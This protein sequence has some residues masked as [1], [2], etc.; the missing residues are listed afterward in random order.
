MA[1][2]KMLSVVLCLVALCWAAPTKIGSGRVDLPY[3]VFKNLN[4]ICAS[5]K[6]LFGKAEFEPSLL[7]CVCPNWPER[8]VS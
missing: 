2:S 1:V 7:S 5:K 3:N 6:C 8:L 4:K